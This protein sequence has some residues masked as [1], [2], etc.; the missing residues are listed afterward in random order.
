MPNRFIFSLRFST[1]V[2]FKLGV[3][4][5]AM[6]FFMT[7][8][9]VN[10]Y[11][12]SVFHAAADVGFLEILSS[13]VAGFRFDLLIFGFLF[14]PLYF[15]IISQAFSERWPRF[16]FIAYKVYFVVAWFLICLSTYMDFFYF[17][18]Q[19]RRMRFADYTSWTP[20]TL[21]E[22]FNSLAPNQAWIFTAITIML[23]TLGYMLI[24]GL[25]FGQWK[26][27]FSPRYG[28]K[29]EVV[30]RVLLP[31]VLIALAARGTVEP[32]HLALEHSEVSN[33][34]AINEMALNA[35]WCFDK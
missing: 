13:F 25:K 29:F 30:W 24:K 11:F 3:L 15:F 20:E 17:A 27:E 6:V 9:R 33:N 12:L 26:D 14:I 22:Q 18:R 5:L 7:L 4:S 28:S 10:L 19:G 16:M 1:K 8:F 32:H 23:F 31:L 21:S 35:V 2:F 34:K